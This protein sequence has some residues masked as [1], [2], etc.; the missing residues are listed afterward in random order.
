M[1]ALF[2]HRSVGRN[3]IEQGQLRDLLALKGVTLHDYDNNSDT[4]TQANGRTSKTTLK[5]PGNNTNPDN[6][7][8]FF[9]RWSDVL[10]EYDLVIIKSCYP[11]SHI[12]DT[13]QLIKTQESYL[14]IIKSFKAHG[15][16]LLIL[17]TPPL[18]PIMTNKLE[19]KL[20]NAL[21]DWLVSVT[22]DDVQVFDL[23]HL[24]AEEAGASRG[25][26]KRKYRR[27][28]PFDNH[29]NKKAN[30]EIAPLL[31]ATITRG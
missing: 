31:A 25:T 22:D 4:L 11:N 27:L 10:N 20:A 18:R 9:S 15:N 17:T 26:L 19:A 5:I 29:P 2:I 8:E 23:H 21:A 6:L 1:K 14:S 3:L 12:K 24:L 16:R 13:D 7:S 30:Q 28:L